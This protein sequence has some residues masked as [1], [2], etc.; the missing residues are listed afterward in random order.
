MPAI[1]TPGQWLDRSHTTAPRPVAGSA[2]SAHAPAG[3]SQWGA[4]TGGGTRCIAGVGFKARR[5]EALPAGPLPRK[6][7]LFYHHPPALPQPAPL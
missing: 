7:D 5:G 3:A 6:P 2:V 4:S 1:P